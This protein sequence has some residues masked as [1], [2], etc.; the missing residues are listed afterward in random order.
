MTGIRRT[1]LLAALTVAVSLGAPAA[2]QA[3]FSD[4]IT[5]P[6]ATISTATVV[7]PGSVT[8]QTVGCDNSRS[9]TVRMSWTPSTSTRV[10]AYRVIAYRANG[11]VAASSTFVATT[12]TATVT[13]DKLGGT[14]VYAVATLTDYGWTKESPRMQALPC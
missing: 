7:A 13:Y 11:M 9:Q 3:A 5:T 4:S 2:A 10:A 12:T 1:L 8:A 6:P 14:L